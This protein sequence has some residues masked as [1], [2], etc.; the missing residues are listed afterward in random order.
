MTKKEFVDALSPILTMAKPNLIQAEYMK[1]E[2]IES[3]RLNPDDEFV[4]ITCEN[5]HRYYVNVT[6]NSF[7]AIAHQV[8]REM[9]SK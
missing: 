8:F 9:E 7:I 6:A 2:D 1:G 4:V 5:R 3:L